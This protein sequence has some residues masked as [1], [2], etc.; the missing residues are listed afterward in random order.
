MRFG[1][2]AA[3]LLAMTGTALADDPP[4]DPTGTAPEPTDEAPTVPDTPPDVPPEPPAPPAKPAAPPARDLVETQVHKQAPPPAKPVLPPMETAASYV[5][6]T[7]AMTS[8]TALILPAGHYEFTARGAPGFGEDISITGSIGGKTELAF[9]FG[10]T[11]RHGEI[12]AVGASLTHQVW[13]NERFAVA[14]AGSLRGTSRPGPVILMG[15]PAMAVDSDPTD[16]GAI[17]AAGGVATACMDRGCRF[18]ANAG[19]QVAS[20]FHGVS[21]L[22]SASIEATSPRTN[23]IGEVVSFADVRAVVAGVRFHTETVSFDLGVARI[24]DGLPAK[25]APVFALSIR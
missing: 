11:D 17:V 3:L 12:T 22:L 23:L 19:A 15:D 16:Y 13:K 21:P 20:D 6:A 2:V 10:K 7:H 5:G 8:G 18:L 4:A 25:Y 9:S 14:A 1:A 24:D